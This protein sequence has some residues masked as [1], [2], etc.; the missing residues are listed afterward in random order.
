[1]SR[2]NFKNH[3]TLAAFITLAVFGLIQ[4]IP[5]HIFFSSGGSLGYI[6]GRLSVAYEF[7]LPPFVALVA[8]AVYSAKGAGTA[9]GSIALI[10]LGRAF[11]FLPF[12]YM[13]AF[14]SGYD[15]LDSL[16]L[17]I[18]EFSGAYFS[19]GV[20]CLGLFGI[21]LLVI[22]N[23]SKGADMR[24]FASGVFSGN[25]IFDFNDFGVKIIFILLIVVFALDMPYVD[26]ISF[27]T[28]FGSSFTLD[29]VLSIIL[30]IL[31]RPLLLLIS[32]TALTLFRRALR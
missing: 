3:P 12:H 29:E 6:A 28:S 13:Q 32:H 24:S 23:S 1:M 11:H 20:F 2:F 22:K 16:L 27:L 30:D 17:S 7:I 18:A 21:A 31:Y 19:F 4:Y 9:I 10:S 5:Y 15:S 8:L 25:A 26:I 14:S